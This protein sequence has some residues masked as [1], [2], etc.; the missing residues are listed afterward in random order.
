MGNTPAIVEF[1]DN[2]YS[3]ESEEGDFYICIR[4]RND[5]DTEDKRCKKGIHISKNDCIVIGY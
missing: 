3:V 2:Y 5:I 1:N 4:L